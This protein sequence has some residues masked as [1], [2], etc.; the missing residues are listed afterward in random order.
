MDDGTFDPA[1]VLSTAQKLLADYPDALVLSAD[2]S[3]LRVPMPSSLALGRH[4][5]LEGRSLLDHVVS[6]DMVLVAKAWHQVLNCGQA[7]TPM[8]LVSAPEQWILLH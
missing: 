4:L 1:V 6:E 7:Q 2:S 3:G 8:R 5:I